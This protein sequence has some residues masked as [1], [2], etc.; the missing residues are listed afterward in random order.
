[1]SGPTAASSLPPC[2]TLWGWVGER[3]PHGKSRCHHPLPSLESKLRSPRTPQGEGTEAGRQL[4]AISVSNFQTTRTLSVSRP[5][6]RANGSRECAPDDRLREAIH[7]RAMKEAGLLRRFRLRSSSYGGQVA[8]RNDVKIRARILAAC[9]AR[10]MHESFARNEGV[11]N[12]GCPLHP[13]PRVR[14][15]K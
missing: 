11:G 4:S 14:N 5:S 10:A 6:L 9:C 13:Q 15:G 3:G 12:A 7:S 8:P 2:G 1:M